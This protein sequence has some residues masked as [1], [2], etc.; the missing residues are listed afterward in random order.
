MHRV[1]VY[2]TLRRN[3]SRDIL[4]YY[5]NAVFVD[6]ASV[7]ARMFD[8][9]SYPGIRLG[10]GPERVVGE[11]FDV[12]DRT[13]KGLD[14]WEGIRPASPSS[15]EYTRRRVKV[16]LD[17]GGVCDAWIYETAESAVLG[18]PA[19]RSGDWLIRQKNECGG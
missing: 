3:A 6:A 1:F 18:R 8:L 12:T 16:H 2:G 7:S 11:V 14:E 10:N 15:G 19:I 9:G 13:L 17:S 5:R 4:Q